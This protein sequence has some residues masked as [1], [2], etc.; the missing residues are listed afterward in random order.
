MEIFGSLFSGAPVE[1]TPSSSYR[2]IEPPP[3]KFPAYRQGH[4][5]SPRF[6]QLCEA[7]TK[8]C[9]SEEEADRELIGILKLMG[10]ERPRWWQFWRWNERLNLPPAALS[11]PGTPDGDGE[12]LKNTRSENL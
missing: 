7:A 3:T 5:W 4:S 6:G 10:Y 8:W 11:E 9:Y 1:R 2:V 12:K